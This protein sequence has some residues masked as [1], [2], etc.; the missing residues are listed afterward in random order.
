M[1]NLS[2]VLVRWATSDEL[3]TLKGIIYRIF[4]LKTG[5]SYIG[6]S[7]DPFDKRYSRKWWKWSH[8]KLLKRDY[9]RYGLSNFRVEIIVS[10]ASEAELSILETYYIRHFNSIYPNG[11]NWNDASRTKGYVHPETRKRLSESLSK[12]YSFIDYKGTV[13]NIKNLNKFCRENGYAPAPLRKM[14]RGDA[15]YAY[16]FARIG[17]PLHLIPDPNKKKLHKIQSPSGE[18]FEFECVEQFANQHG[19]SPRGLHNVLKHKGYHHGGWTLPNTVYIKKPQNL[20]YK[21]IVLEKDGEQY[22]F[23]CVNDVCDKLKVKKR[24]VRQFLEGEWSYLKGHKLISIVV[25][26][27]YG[28]RR[29]LQTRPLILDTEANLIHNQTDVQRKES[30]RVYG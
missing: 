12:T 29:Y 24:T 6:S 15:T 5:W 9:K 19:L 3:A 7:V 16:H 30:L 8:S 1:N 21:D 4:C 18:V 26:E 10:S 17:T 11:Y 22:Y 2:L 20:K 13:Y 23:P 14:L 25:N 28:R 27:E